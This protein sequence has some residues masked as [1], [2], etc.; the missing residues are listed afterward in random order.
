MS[1]RSIGNLELVAAD[2]AWTSWTCNSLRHQARELRALERTA[3][4]KADRATQPPAKRESYLLLAASYRRA[5]EAFEL[6]VQLLED[7]RARAR[8]AAADAG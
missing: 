8:R 7:A 5:A 2:R 4:A 1:E 3:I 6:D